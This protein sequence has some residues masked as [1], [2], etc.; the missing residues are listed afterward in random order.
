[1][2]SSVFVAVWPLAF[3]FSFPAPQSGCGLRLVLSRAG[4]FYTRLLCLGKRRVCVI[5]AIG[6]NLF[7]SLK[8]M[9]SDR[10]YNDFLGHTAPGVQDF[11]DR[12]VSASG[13]AKV[14]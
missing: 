12:N 8:P 13:R 11:L 3:E 6:Q 5:C 9:I 4:W 7:C 14:D 1:M 2:R 10:V